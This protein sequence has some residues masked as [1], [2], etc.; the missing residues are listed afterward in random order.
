MEFLE[1]GDGVPAYTRLDLRAAQRFRLSDDWQA[2][3][4]GVMQNA[5]Q[6]YADFENKNQFETRVFFGLRL[7]Q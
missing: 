7:Y 3:V 1:T 4:Y 5:G 2:E 6:D